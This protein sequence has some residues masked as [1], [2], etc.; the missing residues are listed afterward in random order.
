MVRRLGR[1]ACV[2]AVLALLGPGD[3]LGQ[4]AS[5]PGEPDL[6]LPDEPEAAEPRRIDAGFEASASVAPEDTRFF[7]YTDYRESALRTL[8]ASGSMSL[9]LGRRATLLGEL[10]GANGEGVRVSALYLRLH[11]WA[12]RPVDVQVGRVPPTFGAFPR[13][14]Y[15]ADN[16]LV[17]YPLAYQYLTSLRADAVPSTADDLLAMRGRGWLS[18]FPVGAD[19]PEYGLALAAVSRW[20]TGVQVHV[21]PETLSL[22]ASI[23]AG[24]L[25]NPM[26]RDDNG[27]KQ[28]AARG[29]LRPSPALVLGVSAARGAFLERDLASQL[30]P[31]GGPAPVQRALGLDV[32]HSR[33]YWLVRGEGILSEWGIPGLGSVRALGLSGEGRYKLLPGLYAAARVERL[34]FSRIRGTLFEGRSTPWEAPVFRIE[35]GGGYRPARNVLVKAAYQY[36][37]RDTTRFRSQGLL[38]AQVLVWY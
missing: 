38:A 15:S 10:R 8:R 32:E 25:S 12:G 30:E 1:T 20:D 6:E 31:A 11:P 16:P 14:S 26:V 18:S 13:R 34:G 4:A 27:G 35:A 5:D 17:G 22:T 3:V 19:R 36:N 9:R 28:V 21:G 23:T 37:R 29:E 2:L 24:S 33:G 7:N